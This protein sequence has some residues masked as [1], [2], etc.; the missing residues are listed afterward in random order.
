MAFDTKLK[1]WTSLGLGTVL[2]TGALAG[3]GEATKPAD[4]PAAAEVSE[5][6]ANSHA[7]DDHQAQSS[8]RN[9]G[10]MSWC[11]VSGLWRGWI[12][13]VGSPHPVA[14]RM[15]FP[16]GWKVRAPLKVVC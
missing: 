16:S 15:I 9:L 6:E 7:G 4:T 13:S 8:Q 5:T 3:C 2:M 12:T 11:N 14:W 1:Q 10:G